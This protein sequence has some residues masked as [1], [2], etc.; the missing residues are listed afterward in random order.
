MKVWRREVALAEKEPGSPR[1]G[2]SIMAWPNIYIHASN[3]KQPEPNLNGLSDLELA[4]SAVAGLMKDSPE[5]VTQIG[6]ALGV[7]DGS[8]ANGRLNG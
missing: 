8:A 2:R 5:L 6:E 4:V 1:V 3:T 7:E